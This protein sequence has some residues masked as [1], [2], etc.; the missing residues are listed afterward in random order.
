MEEMLLIELRSE[1]NTGAVEVDHL[2][3]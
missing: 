3:I 2:R 1:A